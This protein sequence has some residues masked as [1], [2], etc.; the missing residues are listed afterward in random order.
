MNKTIMIIAFLIIVY[1][2]YAIYQGDIYITNPV[3]KN[4]LNPDVKLDTTL[5]LSSGSGTD[6]NP[7]NEVMKLQQILNEHGA[8][9]VVDGIFGQLTYNALNKATKGVYGQITLDALVKYFK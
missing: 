9:L 1:L 4:P 2:A 5:L 8:S 6:L 3:S 7:S